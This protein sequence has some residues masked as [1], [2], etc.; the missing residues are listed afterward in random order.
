MSDYDT[1]K[2]L[3]FIWICIY[4]RT[5]EEVQID[6]IVDF[7]NSV[8]CIYYLFTFTRVDIVCNYGSSKHPF[9]VRN[10][11]YVAQHR[12]HTNDL[13]LKRIFMVGF[14]LVGQELAV[15]LT[16]DEQCDDVSVGIINVFGY[17]CGIIITFSVKKLQELFTKLYGNLCFSLLITFGTIFMSLISSL[18]LK[19]QEVVD[20]IDSATEVELENRKKFSSQIS[21]PRLSRLP[22]IK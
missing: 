21:S 6:S 12:L 20:F 13:V 18:E 7:E 16:F 17:L 15:E 3:Q 11:D 14:N 4:S 19:R 5:M 22:S 10:N 8:D 9:G 2:C 1:F